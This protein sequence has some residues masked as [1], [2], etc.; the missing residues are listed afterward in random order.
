MISDYKPSGTPLRVDASRTQCGFVII[1]VEKVG[2]SVHLKLIATDKGK[3]TKAKLG[4]M[5]LPLKLNV[6]EGT[7]LNFVLEQAT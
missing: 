2:D 6:K 7:T 3:L 4:V 5:P 1:E